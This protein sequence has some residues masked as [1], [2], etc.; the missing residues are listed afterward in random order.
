MVA[1]DSF[2]LVMD[3]L[4]ISKCCGPIKCFALT[5][6]SLHAYDALCFEIVYINFSTLPSVLILNKFKKKNKK[7]RRKLIINE[8]KTT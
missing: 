4:S 1:C 8:T 5:S 6:Y 2:H 3:L 7:K